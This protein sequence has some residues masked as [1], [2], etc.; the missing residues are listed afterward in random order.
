MKP[1]RTK[2]TEIEMKAGKE[3]R[4]KEREQGKKRDKEREGRHRPA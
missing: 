3:E 1:R 2:R 4:K